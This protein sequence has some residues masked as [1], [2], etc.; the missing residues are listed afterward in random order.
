MNCP[1]CN[2]TTIRKHAQQD[3]VQSMDL[4]NGNKVTTLLTLPNNSYIRQISSDGK[5]A[6]VNQAPPGSKSPL[7]QARASSM[8][9]I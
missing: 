5:I 6:L 4:S 2:A 1:H 3:L 8:V 9:R 7:H